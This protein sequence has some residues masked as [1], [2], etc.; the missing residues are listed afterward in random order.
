MELTRTKDKI[1][2]TT[3]MRATMATE[4]EHGTKNNQFSHQHN[5]G[6]GQGNNGGPTETNSIN[7]I[8]ANGA[9]PTNA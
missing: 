5:N 3:T 7:N 2:A 6:Q 4:V 1:R 8:N 9:R